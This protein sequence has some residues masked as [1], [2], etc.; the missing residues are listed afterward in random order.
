MAISDGVHPMLTILGTKQRLCDGVSRRQFLKIGAMTGLGGGLTLADYHR[1]RA[2]VG[3]SPSRPEKSVILIYLLGGAAQLDTYD[4]KPDAPTEYRG[5]FRPIRTRV[6]GIDICEHFPRQAAMMDRLAVIRSL[7]ALPPNGH[8][9]AEVMTGRN[10]IDAA[11]GNHPSFG[12]VISRLRGSAA[13]GVPAFVSLRRMSFPNPAIDRQF[14]FDPGYLGTPHRP[15]MP[16]GT[17]LDNLQLLPDIDGARLGQRRT[18]LESFD[19]MR[20]GLDDSGLR[21]GLD[22]F[23]SRAFDVVVSG[24]LRNALD[25]SREDPRVIDRYSLP[26]GP[27]NAIFATG[28]RQGTQVLLA[29]RLVEAGAGFVSLSLGYWD[30][31]GTG[32]GGGFPKLRNQLCP[33]LDRALTALLDDLRQRGMERDVVV[34]VCGEFGRSPRINADAGRDHWLPA[35][36]AV[37][38][39]G[40]LRTGQVIGSTDARGET[41]KDRPYRVSQLLSTIY[42]TIGIDPALTFPS[43][44][45]RPTYLLDDREPIAELL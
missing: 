25:L 19:E 27:R 13:N 29:R 43:T 5:E 1:V 4:L 24:A 17:G 6:P 38:A 41:P 21:E 32:D 44:S 18:L 2:A 28:Y 3:G 8:T 31:H 36:S 35:M 30:T 14:E 37:V 7:S 20:V 23:R 9:D 12:A 22:S 33:Q 15:F 42:R 40:G 16:E 45:G 11:R 39:G 26:D 10:T 34:V